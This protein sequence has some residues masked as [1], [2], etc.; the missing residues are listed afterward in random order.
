MLSENEIATTE[1]LQDIEWLRNE[2]EEHAIEYKIHA[3]R[4]ASYKSHLAKLEGEES[5]Q[6]FYKELKKW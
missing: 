1:Q 2:M 5:A 6:S 3:L 4:L